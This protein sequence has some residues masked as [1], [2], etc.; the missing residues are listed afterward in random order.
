VVTA[1]LTKLWLNPTGRLLIVV[2]TIH[3]KPDGRFEFRGTL[4]LPV[5]QP[6]PVPLDK[7][8]EVVGIGAVNQGQTSLSVTELDVQGVRYRLKE[9]TGDMNAETPG[10][11]GA[12]DFHLS[13]VLDM[14]PADAAVYEQVPGP[15]EPP[16]SQK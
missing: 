14:W 12:V 5:P 1:P 13:Q 3:F 11:G 8:A 10:A 9:G 6:G 7:G 4:L 2:S 15:G 16:A